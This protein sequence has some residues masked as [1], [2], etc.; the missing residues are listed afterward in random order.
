[1]A[2]PIEQLRE[3]YS[4]QHFEDRYRAGQTYRGV[5]DESEWE[6]ERREA[7]VASVLAQASLLLDLQVE[8]ALA[9][10][11]DQTEQAGRGEA[12]VYSLP[13]SFGEALQEAG[14]K[15]IR[16]NY[17][18]GLR[19]SV[20][21]LWAGEV[22]MNGF[23]DSLIVTMNTGLRQAFLLGAKSCGVD[24]ADLTQDEILQMQSF[25]TRQYVYVIGL[26]EW[27][28]QRTRAAG[29]LL[30]TVLA[31]TTLW[32]ARWTEAFNLGMSL[33][34]KDQK[35]MWVVDPAK[36]H[37][38]SCLKLMGK[39]KRMSFWHETGILPQV[40]GATYLEC[41]GWACGCSLQLT[42][43]PCSKGPLPRLP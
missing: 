30:R 11:S 43:Q 42:K 40:A 37:C 36:E 6:R 17:N 21:G 20:R 28:L 34:C 5:V 35:A 27:I 4:P 31:R 2:K 38:S 22:D 29:G 41:G 16:A 39:V 19:A 33:A 7:A 25:I 8:D 26:G 18:K 32:Q 9:V 14:A 24:E 13:D 12:C 23:F 3:E 15:T 10:L 1:M